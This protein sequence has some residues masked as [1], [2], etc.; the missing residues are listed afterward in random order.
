MYSY[1][2]GE[3]EE[4]VAA[5]AS[6]LFRDCLLGEG[7]QGDQSRVGKRK[8]T[9]APQGPSKVWMY[10]TKIYTTDP[11]GVCSVPLL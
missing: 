10:F 6:T 5:C 2:L 8:R 4:E 9:G 7:V 1:P 11:D 3:R